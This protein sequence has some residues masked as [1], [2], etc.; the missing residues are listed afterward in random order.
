MESRAKQLIPDHEHDSNEL[1]SKAIAPFNN[2]DLTIKTNKGTLQVNKEH[3][4]AASPVF[5]KML[6]ANFKEKGAQVINLPDKS[7]ITF[8]HFLRHTLPGFDGIELT[9]MVVSYCM[10]F[11]EICVTRNVIF[12]LLKG[13]EYQHRKRL[14]H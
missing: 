5:H 11:N 4:M 2:N 6:T 12:Q 8:A 1:F 3:L 13:K 10:I 7:P 14:V 9:G